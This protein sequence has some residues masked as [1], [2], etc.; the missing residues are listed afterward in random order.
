MKY[1]KI[2]GLHFLKLGRVT[3]SWCVS[4][5]KNPKVE[6]IKALKKRISKAKAEFKLGV[7]L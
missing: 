1:R 2:G 6:A 5:P 7:A 3:F 4:K